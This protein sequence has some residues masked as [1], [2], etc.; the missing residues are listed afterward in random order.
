MQHF[1]G[2][3]VQ[4]QIEPTTEWSNKL[5]IET[6]EPNVVLVGALQR[7]PTGKADILIGFARDVISIK[8]PESFDV[9]RIKVGSFILNEPGAMLL[10]D[11]LLRN[12]TPEQLSALG[13]ERKKS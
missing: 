8:G 10:I 11:G 7:S 6:H 3:P 2:K 9:E 1:E 5:A 13:Y 12:M 4:A